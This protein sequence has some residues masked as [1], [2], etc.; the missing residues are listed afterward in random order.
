MEGRKAELE[1][2]VVQRT[3]ELTET[4]ERLHD[5]LARG[6]EL[7]VE[8]HE[9]KTAAE[10]ANAAKSQFL[11]NASHELRTPLNAIIGFAEIIAGRMIGHKTEERYEEYG[12]YI[13]KSGRHLLAIINDILDLAKIEARH[14]ELEETEIDVAKL[15]AETMNLVEMRAAAQDLRLSCA[16]PATMPRLYAD[17]RIVKQIL[18]NLAINAVKFSRPKGT[19][20][21]TASLGPDGGIVLAVADNGIGIAAKDIDAV[22]KP[23]VQS[24][25]TLA[26]AH[27]GLGLGLAISKAFAEQHGATLTLASAIGIGT[28]ATLAFPPSR[29]MPAAA[30]GDT[31]HIS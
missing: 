5:Q 28:T 9:A 23:F 21:L 17:R 20:T 1:G 25:G 12:G 16:T 22:F 4:V 8:L 24:D 26:R 11:A 2:E 31:I 10:A 19:V 13:V 3:R 27:E 15:T 29:T 18:L 30:I 7:T 14:H 6:E